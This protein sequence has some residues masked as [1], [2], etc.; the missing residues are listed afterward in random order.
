MACTPEIDAQERAYLGAL[1]NA[2]RM[3]LVG[4]QLVVHCES[5]EQPLRFSRTR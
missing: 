1:Q 3:E 5:L 4:G 2:S